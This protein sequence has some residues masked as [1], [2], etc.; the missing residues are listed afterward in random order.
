MIRFLLRGGRRIAAICVLLAALGA[1]SALLAQLDYDTYDIVQAE[2]VVGTIHVPDRV[3]GQEV[4]AEYRMLS[5]R[6]IYPSQKNPVAT[7][8]RSSTGVHYTSVANFFTTV[9]FPEGSRYVLA[10]A[11]DSASLPRTAE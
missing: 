6:Y 8:I 7:Q 3:A 2:A 4:Y 5:P 1:W 11:F 10:A 9:P